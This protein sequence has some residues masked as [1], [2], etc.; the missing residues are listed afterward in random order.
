MRLKL[1]NKKGND[2]VYICMINNGVESVNHYYTYEA[3]SS[4]S[5]LGSNGIS[6]AS[7]LVNDH[8][9][10]CSFTRQN[11]MNTT[12]FFDLSFPNTYYLLLA[13][14]DIIDGGFS[15]FQS[16]LF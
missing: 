1:L 8:L 4:P 15:F 7:L 3:H 11:K 9:L 2:D 10:M 5:L 6:N 12:N 14:G 16:I 13:K